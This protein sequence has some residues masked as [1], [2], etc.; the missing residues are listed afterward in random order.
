MKPLDNSQDKNL[1]S[2]REFYSDIETDPGVDMDA[3]HILPLSIVPFA[4]SGLKRARLIKN[5][6][7]DSVL[8][9]FSGKTSGSGQV[10]ISKIETV[11]DLS[12][13]KGEID[14]SIIEQLSNINSY[15]VYTLRISLRNL[16]IPVNDLEN[17]QLT[18]SKN[19]ELVKY[20][21][22]FTKPL[23]INIYG[24]DE[25]YIKNIDELLDMFKTPDQELALKNLRKL[26][27]NLQ[28]KLT[29]I[30]NF[31]ED[32]GDIFLSLAYFQEC[33]EKIIPNVEVFIDEIKKLK[34]NEQLKFD[35]NLVKTCEFLDHN[36]TYISKN[37]QNRFYNFQKQSQ[38]MWD[39]ITPD[40]FR[41]VKDIITS[42]HATLGGV[43]CGLAVKMAR[44]QE[45]FADGR[46]GPMQRAEF[47]MSEMRQGIEKIT[48]IE[49]SAPAFSQ[50]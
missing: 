11:F 29:D 21:T 3:L 49:K 14:K 20:M 30:P 8:E 17:L 39:N 28:M 16:N 18:E 45:K 50:K 38:A 24:S 7:L 44:W 34:S 13:E 22:D 32:Y 47:L 12:D 27:D 2:L 19:D 6:Q 15:D 4:T 48:D 1:P 35:R 37:L 40:S 46:G 43:L 9:L 36:L 26:A 23:M 10:E 25:K 42:H 5:V 33:T 41:Y 31:L